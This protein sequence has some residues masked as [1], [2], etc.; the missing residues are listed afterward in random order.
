MFLDGN[1]VAEGA[2]LDADVCIDGMANLYIAGSPVFP[3]GGHANPILTIIALALQLSDHLKARLRAD[4]PAVRTAAP[5]RRTTD[6]VGPDARTR[7]PL[8]ASG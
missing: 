7:G 8:A 1:G 5:A 4:A 6:A 2:D 3:T